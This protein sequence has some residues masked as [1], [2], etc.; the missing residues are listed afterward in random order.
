MAEQSIPKIDRD[1]GMFG[2]YNV[3]TGI[4]VYSSAAATDFISLGEQ[5]F[6][7]TLNEPSYAGQDEASDSEKFYYGLAEK[8]WELDIGSAIGVSDYYAHSEQRVYTDFI[9]SPN[10]KDKDI[11][12]MTFQ[13]D[14]PSEQ[15]YD[16]QIIYQYAQLVGADDD[17]AT[18]GYLSIGC[19]VT[20]GNATS[21]KV[22]NFE[23]LGDISKDSD[24]VSGKKVNE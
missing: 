12:R 9:V 19:Q 2:E 10:Y 20:Y 8:E 13:L 6:Q 24:K 11:L 16:G 3:T 14:L 1:F 17:P 15:Y 23:G 21:A 18:T 4:R 5:S 22:D 7:Y